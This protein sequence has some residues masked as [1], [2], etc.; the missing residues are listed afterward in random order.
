MSTGCGGCWLGPATMRL[1][2]AVP[3]L[4][5][6]V[7]VTALVVFFCVPE[8][9]PVTFA[10]KMHEAPAARA[11]LERLT[12]FDPA[13][14]VIV[15]PPQ[16]PVKPL[17]VLTTCPEGNVSVKPMPLR[18]LAVLGFERLKVSDVLPFRATLAAPKA[19]E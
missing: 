7:E 9:V 3:P 11:A 13:A 12:L 18:E 17:G 1:A 5:A 10:A 15:P 4:P 19:F 2:E 14:A 6:S 16:F 8:I